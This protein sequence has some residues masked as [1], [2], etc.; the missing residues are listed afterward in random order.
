MDKQTVT[1]SRNRTVEYLSNACIAV[2]EKEIN[3]MEITDFGLG[4]H[5]K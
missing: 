1:K 4:C 3:N 5:E 2:K